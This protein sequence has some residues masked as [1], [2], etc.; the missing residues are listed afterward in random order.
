MK[1]IKFLSI[2]VLSALTI[3]TA[4]QE[5]DIFTENSQTNTELK[6]VS[7]VGA[8]SQ[9][10]IATVTLLAGQTTNAGS[11]VLEEVDTNADGINDALS[12]TYNLT[13]G[14]Q[15]SEIHFWIGSSLA[16]MPK[17]KTG[18]P[19][20]GQFPYSSSDV[21]GQS[22]YTLII[23]FASINYTACSA[24]YY[25]AAHASVYLGSRTETAWA[26]GTQMNQKGSWATYFSVTLVDNN[27]PVV[28]GSLSDITVEG[29]SIESA[30]A[31]ATSVSLL[32]TLG[33]SVTDT[34]TLV[35][36]LVVIS[37]DV[38]SGS[39][40]IKIDRKYSIIDECGNAVTISQ[41]IYIE[42]TT[43]PILS[44]QGANL[45][46]NEPEQ[47][48]FTAPVVTDNCGQ[49]VSVSFSDVTTTEIGQS[50][51]TRTWTATDACGNS[52]SVSQSITI[53]AVTVVTQCTSWQTETGFGG[54]SAG[55]GNAW[56]YY[57]NGNGVQTIWAG[58]H[59]NAGSVTLVNGYLHI[60]LDNGWELQNVSEPVKIQAY[61]T[62]PSSRP[63]AG[64]FTTYKGTSLTVAVGSFA[65]YVIHLDVR[66]CTSN[67]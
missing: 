34:R 54:N 63:A 49:N 42:D 52:S 16:T 12:A 26:A 59:I 66:K 53:K 35:S 58:Q 13:G 29:C 31:A 62:L 11:L 9:S 41:T 8:G 3:L 57:Y 48:L 10:S 32:Q 56:W 24:V 50:T 37:S 51:V 28:S 17:T 27:P 36:N 38:S 67:N 15:L 25:V 61:N 47:P 7:V 30:P 40:P 14:W 39:C 45:T 1:S 19:Q 2:V 33:L 18:N 44:G 22:S 65:Y 46:I 21:S 6:S 64:Q 60:T 4:C 20:I 55:N 43:A 5:E 23:P